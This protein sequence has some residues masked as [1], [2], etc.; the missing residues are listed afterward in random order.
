MTDYVGT[1]HVGGEE[2][3]YRNSNTYGSPTWAEMRNVSDVDVP[4][5]RSEVEA[6]V[7]AHYPFVGSLVGKRKVGLSWKMLKT[8]STTDTD[9]TA[10]ITAYEAGTVVEFA[11]ADGAIA[12]TGTK[13]RRVSCVITKM[14][15]SAPIDGQVEYSFEAA[16]AV[17]NGGNLPSRTTT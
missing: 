3:L 1:A 10:M 4:D 7:R 9:L 5:S 2:K 17:N 6:Q 11:I 16:F 15:E 13:Y 8:T 14:D 12:T